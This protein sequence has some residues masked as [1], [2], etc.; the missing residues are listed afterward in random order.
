MF[1]LPIKLD[2][3]SFKTKGRQNLQKIVDFVILG[4]LYLWFKR[5]VYFGGDA[6]HTLNISRSNVSKFTI[7]KHLY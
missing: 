7:L 3:M 2:Q 6:A 5:G 1:F 4:V